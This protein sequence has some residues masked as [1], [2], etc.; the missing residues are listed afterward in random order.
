[1]YLLK[2]YASPDNIKFDYVSILQNIFKG[3]QKIK[4]MYK[5]YGYRMGLMKN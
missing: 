3:Y 5:N 2:Q 1:M 4:Y